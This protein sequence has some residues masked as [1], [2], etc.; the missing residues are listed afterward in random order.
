MAIP[1]RTVVVDSNTI[2]TTDWF[3]ASSPWNI[4]LYQAQQG[5]IRLVVPEMVVMEVCGRFRNQLTS[6]RDKGRGHRE[7][8]SKLGVTVDDDAIDVRAIAA[9]YEHTLRARISNASGVITDLSSVDIRQL[10]QR[11]VDRTRPFDQEGNGFRDSILWQ[12]FLLELTHSTVVTLVSNDGAFY[13]SKERRDTLHPS[14][15]EEV[16]ASG[17]DPNA[18]RYYNTLG[19]Y[20]KETGTQDIGIS[21]QVIDLITTE[22]SQLNNNIAEAIAQAEILNKS[23]GIR[24]I[25]EEVFGPSASLVDVVEVEGTTGVS[26]VTLEGTVDVDVY[27]EWWATNIDTTW[28]ETTKTI[29]Y[30][31][32]CTY[33]HNEKALADFGAETILVDIDAD[34]LKGAGP[35]RWT[36][37]DLWKGRHLVNGDDELLA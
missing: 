8:L 24:L 18:I 35:D 37:G 3:L 4:T 6:L 10:V 20:L 16:E 7:S 23:P 17:R 27:V 33:D 25:I 22:A 1:H 30:T 9:D 11:A 15:V 12:V 34:D 31:V 13:E 29:D 5:Y 19:K 2:V 21:S 14:L 32:T 28:T 36:H 26:L